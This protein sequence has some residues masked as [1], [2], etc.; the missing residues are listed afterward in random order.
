MSENEKCNDPNVREA[1]PNLRLL[2]LRTI[3]KTAEGLAGW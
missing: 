1:G 2:S 3:H